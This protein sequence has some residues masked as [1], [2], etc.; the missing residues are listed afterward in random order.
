MRRT[1]VLFA[2][3]PA[4]QARDKGLGGPG[5][6]DLFAAIGSGWS[7]AARR[8]RATL[9]VAAPPEDLPAWRRRLGTGPGISWHAQRGATFGQRLRE[10]ARRGSARGARAVVVG[11]DVP[12]SLPR[13]REAFR[14]LEA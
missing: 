9:I 11:G 2:R 10:A 3:E 14:A 1:L 13:L 6:A 4:R 8:A 7:E 12:P 5:A